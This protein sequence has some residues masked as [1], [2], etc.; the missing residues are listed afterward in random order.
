MAQWNERNEAQ[1]V[2][3][4]LVFAIRFDPTL[5]RLKVRQKIAVGENNPARLGRCARGVKDFGNGASCGCIAEIRADI[6]HTGRAAYDILEIV[7]DHRRRR[8]GQLQLL[9]VTQ[10]E[11]HARILCRALNE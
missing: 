2:K 8:A 11:L 1:R 5:E 7:D 6:W 3:P 10:D 4:A 9:T